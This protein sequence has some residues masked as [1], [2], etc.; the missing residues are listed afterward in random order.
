MI[1]ARDPEQD[2]HAE[3]SLSFTVCE[4][5]GIVEAVWRSGRIVQVG[6]QRRSLECYSHLEEVKAG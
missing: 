4:D 6:A 2:V 3:K 1:M 5:Q